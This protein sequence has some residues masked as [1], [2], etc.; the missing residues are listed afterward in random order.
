M[1]VLAAEAPKITD[2][3][4]GWGSLLAVLMSTSLKRPHGC[5]QSVS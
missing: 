1:L 5:G 2:W 3:M 4:Q